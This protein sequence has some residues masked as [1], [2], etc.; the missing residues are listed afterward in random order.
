MKVT[1][2]GNILL[3]FV[4]GMLFDSLFVKLFVTY[5]CKTDEYVPSTRSVMVKGRL[6]FSNKYKNTHELNRN[7]PSP[8]KIQTCSFVA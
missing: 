4:Y 5:F 6:G 7:P 8:S 3:Q 1:E 2:F